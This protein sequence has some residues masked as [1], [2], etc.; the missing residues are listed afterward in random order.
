MRESAVRQ[1]SEQAQP[2]GLRER[3]KH[4]KLD[5]IQ[6]AAWNLFSRNGFEATTTRAVAE[7]AGV[8][9]GT[10]FLY[11][12]DKGDL[13]ALA[14][15]DAVAGTLE[16]AVR[17]LPSGRPLLDRLMHLFGAFFRLFERDSKL[18]REFVKEL[19]I[20]GEPPR[21]QMAG[22]MRRMLEVLAEQLVLA[23]GAGEVATAVPASGASMACFAVY[24]GSLVLW[25]DGWLA[26]GETPDAHLRR[27][28]GSQLLG[29]APVNRPTGA[30][31]RGAS[32][33]VPPV[34]RPGATTPS[35][36]TIFGEYDDGFVD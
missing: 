11:A 24:Y 17:T 33:G 16:T 21:E 27:A 36:P 19:L 10:L 32:A 8:G 29:L 34:S 15:Q 25:L 31:P 26:P 12:R 6:K 14:Y 18:A 9:T 30:E 28:L 23:Q 1:G 4:E 20:A 2:A 3:N 22:V 35:R 5:R 13:L 7:A